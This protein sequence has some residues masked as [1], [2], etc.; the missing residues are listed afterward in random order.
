MPPVLQTVLIVSA[1][2]AIVTMAARS[3]SDRLGSV[4]FGL[5]IGGAIANI[6][7][8]LGDG[9]VTDY[10]AVGTFPVFNAADACI[11]I[12]VG[13]LLLDAWMKRKPKY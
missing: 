4:A 8:R 3:K 12:G 10:I 7:D 2:V 1:L 13:L 11:S 9:F 5:V 6:I